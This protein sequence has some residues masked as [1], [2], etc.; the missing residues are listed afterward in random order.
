MSNLHMIYICFNKST[1]D[2]L[3]YSR[4][5]KSRDIIIFYIFILSFY[6]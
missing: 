3:Y 5:F 6:A 2:L 1:G 4:T